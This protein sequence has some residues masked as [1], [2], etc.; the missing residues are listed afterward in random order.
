MR[1]FFQKERKKVTSQQIFNI[2]IAIAPEASCHS[3]RAKRRGI[4]K[5][6]TRY[7]T[8]VRYDTDVEFRKHWPTSISSP[9]IKSDKWLAY[10][11][12]FLSASNVATTAHSIPPPYLINRKSIQKRY[13]RRLK[14]AGTIYPTLQ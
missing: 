9:I 3:D 13:A 14:R 4:S 1:M 12:T 11:Y 8:F 7:L 5:R 2:N 10:T 6:H